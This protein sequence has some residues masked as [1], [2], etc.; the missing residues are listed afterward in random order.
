ML[1]LALALGW[2]GMYI[3]LQSFYYYHWVRTSSISHQTSHQPSR[4]ASIV[5]VVHNEAESIAATL[6]G[7]LHQ[8]YPTSLF[9]IILVDDH[10][11]D[12]TAAIVQTPIFDRVRYFSLSDHPAFIHPPAYKKSGI[13]LGVTKALFDTIIVTDADCT[14]HPVWLASVMQQFDN[15]GVVFQASP[16]ILSPS[17]SMIG[18]M[19]EVEQLI[20]MLVTGAGIRSGLHD[21]ANGANMAFDK[22]AFERVG[23]YEGNLEYASGDD[24]FL[25]EKMRAAYPDRIDFFGSLQGVVYTGAKKNWRDLLRQRLRWAGK[26]KG[27]QRKTILNI[28]RGIGLYHVIM[29]GLLLSAICSLITWW[30]LMIMLIAKW[31]ADYLLIRSAASFFGRSSLLRFFIPLQVMY[32]GYIL[33]LGWSLTTG[34]QA[35]WQRK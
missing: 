33:L 13:N 7:L 23:G 28:W 30:P 4:G 34:R 16:V 20:L 17:T 29:L 14:H 18:K 12:Q 27:L 31:I 22:K 2:A 8:Q 32:T 21:L 35:D 11:D 1:I 9:E 19:Q 26:N 3:G 25:I 5:M 10:S 6:T 15:T 24:L